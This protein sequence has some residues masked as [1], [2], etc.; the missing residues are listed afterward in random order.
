MW[1][2]LCHGDPAKCQHCLQTIVEALAEE[3]EYD[4]SSA[5]NGTT[6]SYRL[7][8]NGH[9]CSLDQARDLRRLTVAVCYRNS[10][11]RAAENITLADFDLPIPVAIAEAA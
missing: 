10:G 8:L 11:G 6:Q 5:I 4:L 9:P 7:V 3:F 1:L 2:Q